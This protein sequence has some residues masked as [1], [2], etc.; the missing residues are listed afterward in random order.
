MDTVKIHY[1]DKAARGL[2]LH[3]LC[4]LLAEIETEPIFVCIGSDRHILDCFG[5]LTGTMLQANAPDLRVFGTLDQPLHAQN[6][7]Q[8]IKEARQQNFGRPMIAI[9]ASVGDEQEIGLIQ[10]RQ[11]GL[12][13]GKA[14]AKNLPTV[15][16]FSLTGVVD[17]RAS[18][19]GSRKNKN[20]G[21]ALVYR[22][23][24]LVSQS[25]GDWYRSKH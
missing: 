16:Q 9:D 5:P 11:G 17:V 14:F 2:L 24:Q 23:A 22:M 13:P 21:L 20:Q 6:L 4:A 19:W 18:H 7:L 8:G 1:Q 15:G 25:I 3:A 10:L 12:V